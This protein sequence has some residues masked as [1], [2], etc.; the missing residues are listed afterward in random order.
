MKVELTKEH[1]QQLVTHFYLRVQKDEL[2]GPIFNDVAGVDWEHHIPLLCQFW[3]SVMLKTNEY[4]GN[5]YMKHVLIGQE[6]L[7]QEEYFTHWLD[8]FGQEAV[9]YLP[10]DAA[11]EIVQRALLI[12]KSLQFAMLNKH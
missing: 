10:P 11:A 1:I 8:L 4:K 2:L 5:A 12:A 3:N 9:K 7:I 6:A